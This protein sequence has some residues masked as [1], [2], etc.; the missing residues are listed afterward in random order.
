MA[1]VTPYESLADLAGHR[2]A[3]RSNLVVA[4]SA[5]ISASFAFGFSVLAGIYVALRADVIADGSRWLPQGVEI[6]LTQPNYMG[7]SLILSLF[8][9]WWAYSA[10][11]GGDRSNALLAQVMTLLFSLGFVV[12]AFYLF[13]ILDMTAGDSI[14]A[15]LIY[16]MAGAHL[17]AYLAGMCAVMFTFMR[18]LVGDFE[19]QRSEALL[20]LAIYWTQVSAVY[21]I[22]WYAVY[23]TK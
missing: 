2:E 19:G 16:T 1:D 22:L 15:V 7:V 8:T 12:Q 5:V 17:L 4:G 23:I 18:T 13:S 20:A 10:A 3:K 11:K 9:I 6:P 14:Q 21:A